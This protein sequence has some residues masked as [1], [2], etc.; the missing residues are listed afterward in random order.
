MAHPNIYVNVKE[1]PVVHFLD[2]LQLTSQRPN[3]GGQKLGQA[4]CSIRHLLRPGV[5]L[6][7]H[8]L[9]FFTT[10]TLPRKVQLNGPC[11]AR[12]TFHYL[13]KAS[14]K[15]LGQRGHWSCYPL[16]FSAPLAQRPE[17]SIHHIRLCQ[18]CESIAHLID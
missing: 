8:S 4:E 3:N 5:T 18:D 7:A 14:T 2:W 13:I 16:A 17:S 11:C 1:A 15:T 9:T 12:G 6:R 10:I